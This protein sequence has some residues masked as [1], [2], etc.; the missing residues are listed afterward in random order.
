[1]LE[2]LIYIVVGLLS[3]WLAIVVVSAIHRFIKEYKGNQP[4]PY[5]FSLKDLLRVVIR[6]RLEDYKLAITLARLRSKHI[7]QQNLEKIKSEW[8]YQKEKREKSKNE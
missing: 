7:R 3:L 4:H 8:K 1:M 5:S 2:L 6:F